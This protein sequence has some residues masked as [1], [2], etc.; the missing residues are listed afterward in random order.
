MSV[1]RRV[2]EIRSRESLPKPLKQA[3]PC[4]P[5]DSS[6]RVSNL[7][8]RAVAGSLTAEDH[9]AIAAELF[10]HL[11]PWLYS[12]IGES[13]TNPKSDT[14]GVFD[15]Q[16]VSAAVVARE[17]GVKRDF[18]YRHSNR[19]GARRLGSG[20]RA[21]LRFNLE[22]ARAALEENAGLPIGNKPTRSKRRPRK[23]TSATLLPIGGQRT[24]GL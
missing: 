18:V 13:A 5:S 15:G 17:L 22:V 10:E 1:Y 12:P 7:D 9:R 8:E 11:K 14:R 19:L 2:E 4:D 24:N 6:V 20:T 23:T 3:P 21:R 16:L